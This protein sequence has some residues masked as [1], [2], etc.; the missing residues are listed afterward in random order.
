MWL[1]G[2]FFLSTIGIELFY[3]FWQQPLLVHNGFE[4]KYFG[5]IFAGMMVVRGIVSW[6]T[7]KIE[8]KLKENWSIISILILQVI[9]F[10]LFSFSNAYVLIIS[11]AILNIIIEF[12]KRIKLIRFQNRHL[13]NFMKLF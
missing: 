13:K 3:D 5:F 8:G 6:Y 10:Y 12:Y 2:F 7:H 11:L 9:M 4:V 1:I